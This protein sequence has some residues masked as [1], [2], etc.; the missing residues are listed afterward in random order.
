M[1][2]PDLTGLNIQDTYQRILQVSSSGEIS[3]GTG[4]LF[5][6]PTASHAL[7]AL[8]ASHEI[9]LET[10][11]TNADLL[12]VNSTSDLTSDSLDTFIPLISGPTEVYDY[13]SQ[14]ITSSLKFDALTGGLSTTING[15]SF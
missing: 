9:T 7:Y 11:A 2:L 8:S 13:H 3:D 14:Y 1:A 15:G 6:P 4:S 5:V 12:K 10:R